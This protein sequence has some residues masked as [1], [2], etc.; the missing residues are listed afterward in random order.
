M[1]KKMKK[2]GTFSK[3]AKLLEDIFGRHKAMVEVNVELNLWIQGDQG[4][5]RELRSVASCQQGFGMLPPQCGPKDSATG[6]EI[7]AHTRGL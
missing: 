4:R 6:R 2:K 7:P 1:G 5:H 3:D